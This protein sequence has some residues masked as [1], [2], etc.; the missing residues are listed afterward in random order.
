M[1][2]SLQGY[3]KP[4]GHEDAEKELAEVMNLCSKYPLYLAESEKSEFKNEHDRRVFKMSE[5]FLFIDNIPQ[6]SA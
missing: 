3:I 1:V 4:H 5:S 2:Q 6:A